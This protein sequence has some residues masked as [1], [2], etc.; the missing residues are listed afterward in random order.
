[1]RVG[2]YGGSFDPPHIGHVMVT[3]WALSAGQIDTLLIVPT[4][5]HAFNKSHGADYD[6]RLALCE[7]AFTN[8]RNVEVSAIEKEIGGKSRTLHTLR[9]L[10]NRRPKDEFALVVGA[11]VLAKTDDWYRWDDIIELAHP[12]VVGRQGYPQPEG[13]PIEIPNVSS[14]DIRQRLLA[15]QDVVGLVPTSVLTLIAERNLY[16]GV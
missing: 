8:F 7:A 9:E 3:A 1:M 13:C 4:W 14:T 2:V 10:K 5:S 16:R 6:T 15:A 12:L 11:D